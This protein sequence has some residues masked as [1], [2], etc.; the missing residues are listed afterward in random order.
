MNFASQSLHQDTGQGQRYECHEGQLGANAQQKIQSA[1][2]KQYRVGAVHDGRP[3]QHAD[4]VQ[5]IGHPG[6]NVAGAMLLEVSG[7][8]PLQVAEQVI[9]QIELNLPGN[10]DDDP[11][12]EKEEHALG[13]GNSHQQPGIEQD[14]LPGDAVVQ[15]VDGDANDLGEEYPDDIRKH[16]GQSA[17]DKIAAIAAQI[18]KQ[19]PECGKH[20]V[21]ILILGGDQVGVRSSRYAPAKPKSRSGDQAASSVGRK[22]T[23]P[24]ASNV[25]FATQ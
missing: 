21:F 18:R 2:R 20:V 7:R 24:R 9:A 8:L 6:H 1:D 4:C 16:G 19:R 15:V 14:L 17:P 10:A 3:Q 22:F 5:V 23:S 25:L 12:G 11:A 13:R